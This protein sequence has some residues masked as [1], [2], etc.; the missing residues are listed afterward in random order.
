MSSSGHI[1]EIR[2]Y[3]GRY[4]PPIRFIDTPGGKFWATI[5]K[6]L[7]VYFQPFPVYRIGEFNNLPLSVRVYNKSGVDFQNDY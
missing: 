4:N 5:M 1:V 3:T 2:P 6:M 7:S